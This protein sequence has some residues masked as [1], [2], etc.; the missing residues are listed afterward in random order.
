M[1][2]GSLG[3]RIVHGLIAAT[4]LLP[5]IGQISSISEK[6]IVDHYSIRADLQGR[7]V[8]DETSLE[9]HPRI[10]RPI[11]VV[12]KSLIGI[13]DPEEFKEEFYRSLDKPTDYI[14]PE[15]RVGRNDYLKDTKFYECSCHGFDRFR[16]DRRSQIEE[17]FVQEVELLREEKEAL[18]AITS[19]GAGGCLQDLIILGKLIQRG[20]TNI[21]VTFMD[22]YVFNHNRELAQQLESMLNRLPGINITVRY[23]PVIPKNKKF[24]AMYAL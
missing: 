3:D 7:N 6:L 4:Q 15:Q 11:S 1:A 21:D 13:E 24:D 20:Y 2:E 10:P 17:T 19:L 5:V 12:K 23:T 16:N 18:L 8:T 14:D 22:P 9:E